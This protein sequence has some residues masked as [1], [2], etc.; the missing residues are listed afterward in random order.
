MQKVYR[1]VT[2]LFF[3]CI[4]CMMFFTKTTQ[5]RFIVTCAITAFLLLFSHI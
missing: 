5:V 2:S 1:F 4:F 3:V